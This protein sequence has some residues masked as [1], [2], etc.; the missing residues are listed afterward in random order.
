MQI[1]CIKHLQEACLNFQVTRIL[2][3]EPNKNKMA[4]LLH[5]VDR[6]ADISDS[7]KNNNNVG[8]D[9]RFNC[10]GKIDFSRSDSSSLPDVCCFLCTVAS[11]HH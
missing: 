4:K 5:A 6:R 3:K 11:L 8:A 1:Y 7:N 9:K 10:Y 2:F